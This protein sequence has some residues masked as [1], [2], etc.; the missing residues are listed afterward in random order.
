MFRVERALL[1]INHAAGV[2]QSNAMADRLSSL[3][4]ER[5]RELAQVKIESVDTHEAARDCTREFLRE[6]EAP[7]IVVA[8]GG[9]GTL[10]AVIEGICDLADANALPGPERVRV[11]A[12]RMGSG[13]VL[14]KQFGAPRDPLVGLES[15]LTNLNGG[16]TV[17]CCVM[18]CEIWDSSGRSQIRHAV[19]LGGLGQFGRIPSDLARWHQRLPI[20]HKSAARLLG[21]ETL[22]NIEYGL[23]LLIRSLYCTISPGS[24]ETIE[25][26]GADKKERMQLLSGVVMNFPIRALPLKPDVRV[27]DEA[28]CIYLIPLIG[29]H[30]PLLHVMAPKLLACHIH[31][32]RVEKTRPMDIR[33][34][35]REA[36][37]F[38]LDEDPVTT[39]GRLNLA[40]A[41]SIAFVPGS[42]YQTINEPGVA[43]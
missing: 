39:C 33:F 5:L 28:V 30:S 27:E 23:A 41:G 8:G 11:G 1:I 13:N 17:P 16:R 19:T 43:A 32:I 4:K 15:V 20:L 3:F 22:T 7:A 29:R 18:R 36:V 35:D 2:G 6:S 12:L 42:D 37:N 9:G 26:Q 14:A 10:R 21:V 31:C 24:A 34:V 40:V 38:F 25:I